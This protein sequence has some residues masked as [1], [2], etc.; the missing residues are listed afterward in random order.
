MKHKIYKFENS[1][2]HIP[3]P[4]GFVKKK[5]TECSPFT[6][7]KFNGVELILISANSTFNA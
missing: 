6:R 4:N 1:K 5:R 3:V 7:K 2:P